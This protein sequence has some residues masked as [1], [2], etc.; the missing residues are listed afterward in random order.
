MNQISRSVNLCNS[1]VH[2]PTTRFDADSSEG[3]C[4]TGFPQ[5]G[6]NIECNTVK[7]NVTPTF[8]KT[9]SISNTL[10]SV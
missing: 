9:D 7:T 3:K 8:L 10:E 1:K 5:N 2:S 4:Y 6:F